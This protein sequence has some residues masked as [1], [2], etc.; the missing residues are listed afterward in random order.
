MATREYSL[1]DLNTLFGLNS[2]TGQYTAP[3][4]SPSLFSEAY[5][6]PWTAPQGLYSSQSPWGK[7]SVGKGLSGL[8]AFNPKYSSFGS[9][10]AGDSLWGLNSLADSPYSVSQKTWDWM[11]GNSSVASNA[12]SA[13]VGEKLS[14]GMSQTEFLDAL[15]KTNN[16]NWGDMGLGQK[17]GV[18]GTGLQALSGLSSAYLGFKNLSLAKKQLEENSKYAAT[19]LSNQAK[20]ANQAL[21]SNIRSRY[22]GANTP[23]EDAEFAKYQVA[24]KV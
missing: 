3:E 19:N 5:D 9:S 13:N 12:L 14:Q 18:V 15:R 16:P 23:A 6:N 8:T 21:E 4:S 11:N 20:L 24:G 17:V 1:Q 7:Y 2:A 10:G 22:A